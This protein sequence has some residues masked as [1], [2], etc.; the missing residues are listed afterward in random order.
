MSTEINFEPVIDFIQPIINDWHDHWTLL[1]ILDGMSKKEQDVIHRL[2]SLGSLYYF[3]K[4]TLRKH[5]LTEHL[6]KSI[7]DSLE[8]DS[9]KEVLEIPRDPVNPINGR[10]SAA[11][12]AT[13]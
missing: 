6:H 12:L 7:C 4:I 5:R 9:L 3:L 2:N 11:D 1:P 13:G 10:S 8:K